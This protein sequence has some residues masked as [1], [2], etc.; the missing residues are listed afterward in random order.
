MLAESSSVA[1]SVFLA[2]GGGNNLTAAGSIGRSLVVDGR[3]GNDVVTLAATVNITDNFFA[4]LGA[5]DNIVTHNG[6]VDG[7]F[8]VV[9]KNAND[10]VTIAETA[11]IGGETKLGLGEQRFGHGWFGGFGSGWHGP[12]GM[13]APMTTSHVAPSP[14]ASGTKTSL[15]AALSRVAQLLLR[16]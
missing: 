6:K 4:R 12:D 13:G 9:S 7:N 16:R 11:I 15:T 10:T 1:K 3:D 2:L 14:T 8:K 5:G